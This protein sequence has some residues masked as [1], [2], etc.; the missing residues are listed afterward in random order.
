MTEDTKTSTG[1][2]ILEMAPSLPQKPVGTILAPLEAFVALNGW[3]DQRLTNLDDE[4]L[5]FIR[6]GDPALARLPRPPREHEGILRNILSSHLLFGQL[7]ATSGTYLFR[8]FLSNSGVV[9]SF[10]EIFDEFL[11][12]AQSPFVNEVNSGDMGNLSTCEYWPT[13]EKKDA[14]VDALMNTWTGVGFVLNKDARR[15]T[16]NFVAEALTNTKVMFGSDAAHLFHSIVSAIQRSIVLEKPI[17]SQ[18]LAAPD[19]KQETR[20]SDSAYIF[21]LVFEDLGW[22][23]SPRNFHDIQVLASNENIDELRKF[24][25]LLQ[26][27]VS[28]GELHDVADLRNAI[29][30]NI[31]GYAKKPWS[32]RVSQIVAY[33]A[34]PAGV[35]EILLGATMVGISLSGVGLAS[36]FISDLVEHRKDGHWL[37]LPRNFIKR[38]TP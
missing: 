34:V 20:V 21:R 27:K 28:V 14:I 10:S 24:I 38:D 1:R 4:R 5:K 6:F 23:P 18:E 15:N 36:Q 2:V 16:E 29:V 25:H 12:E 7:D 32:S 9:A 13:I 30:K 37:S 8:R 33:I 3:L 31:A 26:H 35:A 11:P 17:F 19:W 22:F